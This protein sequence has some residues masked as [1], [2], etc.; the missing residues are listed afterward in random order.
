MTSNWCGWLAHYNVILLINN[1]KRFLCTQF[2]VHYRFL[3][4]NGADVGAVNYDGDLAVDI[5]ECEAM[6]KL[7]RE[8]IDHKGVS[9]AIVLVVKSYRSG[10][11]EQKFYYK[12]SYGL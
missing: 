7:L 6:E 2:S 10:R 5:T 8:A 12:G 9:G 4:E 3:I 1:L 11:Q